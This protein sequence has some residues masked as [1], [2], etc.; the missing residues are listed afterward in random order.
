MSLHLDARQRAML[1]EMGIALWLPQPAARPPQPAPAPRPARPVLAGAPQPNAAADAAEADVG[2]QPGGA[3][4][5]HTPA[6]PQTADAIPTAAPAATR[7]ASPHSHPYPFA[8]A[9]MCIIREGTHGFQQIF[10]RLRRRT[11]GMLVRQSITCPAPNSIRPVRG[12]PCQSLRAHGPV[13][14]LAS[15]QHAL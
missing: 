6:P 12:K 14:Q 3:T 4:A 8:H 9:K 7:P 10:Q 15:Q 2:I 13:H 5:P 1:Q 11:Q